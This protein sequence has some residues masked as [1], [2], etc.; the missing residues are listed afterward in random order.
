MQQCEWTWDKGRTKKL[1]E[2]GGGLGAR[3]PGVGKCLHTH[4]RDTVVVRL[5]VHRCVYVTP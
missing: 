5:D 2:E 1:D 4:V 3:E